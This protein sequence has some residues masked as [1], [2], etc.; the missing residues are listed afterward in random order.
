VGNECESI[1]DVK[2][3]GINENNML[4]KIPILKSSH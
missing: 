1:H 4:E 3:Q 2:S